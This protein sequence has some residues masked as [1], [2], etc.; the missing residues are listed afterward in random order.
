MVASPNTHPEVAKPAQVTNIYINRSISEVHVGFLFATDP[1]CSVK[2]TDK[3][4]Y[5]CTTPVLISNVAISSLLPA[6][7][8]G[9]SIQCGVGGSSVRL[10]WEFRQ[11]LVLSTGRP[12]PDLKAY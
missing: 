6:R 9:V 3:A 10:Y 5:R 7:S 11:R 12:H 1:M 4:F 2:Q 8:V